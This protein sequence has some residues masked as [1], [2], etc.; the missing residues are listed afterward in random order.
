LK[1]KAYKAQIDFNEASKRMKEGYFVEINPM[2]KEIEERT[3][4]EFRQLRVFD[5]MDVISSLGD[6]FD[7]IYNPLNISFRGHVEWTAV[8]GVLYS[9]SSLIGDKP[10]TEETHNYLLNSDEKYKKDFHK[11]EGKLISL[12]LH[13]SSRPGSNKR[14]EHF[15]EF[16]NI[17]GF[18]PMLCEL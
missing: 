18:V 1:E 17:W 4:E 7:F 8:D 15:L 16:N 10:R 2:I 9:L 13:P 14:L 12:N 5:N 3:R 6:G 11:I